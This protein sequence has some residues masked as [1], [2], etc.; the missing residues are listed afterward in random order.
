MPRNNLQSKL[1]P[2]RD[3]LA[4]ELRQLRLADKIINIVINEREKPEGKVRLLW[5]RKLVK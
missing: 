5:L 3:K 4:N 1:V 2:E